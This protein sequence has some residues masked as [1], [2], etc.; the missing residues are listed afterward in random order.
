M[1]K[2]TKI[3]NGNRQIITIVYPK[4]KTQD[5]YELSFMVETNGTKIIINRLGLDMEVIDFKDL[6]KREVQ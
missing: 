3:K 2:E 5:K 1:T 6:P 4:T